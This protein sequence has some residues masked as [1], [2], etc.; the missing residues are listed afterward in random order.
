MEYNI[1]KAASN[2]SGIEFCGG[3]MYV[4]FLFLCVPFKE[5]GILQSIIPNTSPYFHPI[6]WAFKW[7]IT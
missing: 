2:Y 1:I 5:Y 4:Y 7:K 6:Y 3:L